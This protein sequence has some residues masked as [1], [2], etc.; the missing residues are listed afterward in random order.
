M[1]KQATEHEEGGGEGEL[2]WILPPKIKKKLV[3]KNEYN[4]QKGVLSPRIYS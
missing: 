4:P 3:Y 1:S 2:R